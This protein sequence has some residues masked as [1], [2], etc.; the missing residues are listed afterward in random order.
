MPGRAGKWWNPEDE[1]REHLEAPCGMPREDQAMTWSPSGRWIA[2]HS[3]REQSD[4]IWLRPVDG[5]APDRR[6]TLLG[7]GAEV[8]WPRWSPDGST[9]LLDGAS[10]GA[11]R[12]VLFRYESQF[13]SL[14]P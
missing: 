10:P 13:R 1:L 3:H 2:L 6:I 5:S 9:V 4:D 14:R 8:G 11:G 7:R 12:S